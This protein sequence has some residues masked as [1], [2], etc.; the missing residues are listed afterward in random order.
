MAFELLPHIK[1]AEKEKLKRVRPPR[2]FRD[3]NI[4]LQDYCEEENIGQGKQTYAYIILNEY[5]LIINQ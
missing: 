2:F 1:S 4:P 5:L 3:S